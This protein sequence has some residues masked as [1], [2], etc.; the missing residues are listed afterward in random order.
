[1]GL[2]A[3]SYPVT[4]HHGWKTEWTPKQKRG[5]TGEESSL[6]VC[7]L[8]GYPATSLMH[9]RP[10]CL[11]TTPS[12]VAWVI[13]RQLTIKKNAP[14]T[15]PPSVTLDGGDCSPEFLCLPVVVVCATPTETRQYA[16]LLESSSTYFAIEWILVFTTMTRNKDKTV[17]P[18][19]Q[20]GC[21]QRHGGVGVQRGLIQAVLLVKLLWGMTDPSQTST[22][23]WKCTGGQALPGTVVAPP[24]R[25]SK[26]C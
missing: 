21:L 26:R 1:M 14:E 18:C 12:T 20:A 9:P 23:H 3:L 15:H 2:R 11:K 22:F 24:S 4:V 25:R 8:L 10:T 5:R 13:L 6:D 17:Q 7:F 16:Y 19:N